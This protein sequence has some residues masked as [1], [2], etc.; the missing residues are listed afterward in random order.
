M[1]LFSVASQN[2]CERTTERLDKGIDIPAEILIVPIDSP[3][4]R[5]YFEEDKG[6]SAFKKNS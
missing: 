4:S 2:N 1:P 3:L 6:E 5:T